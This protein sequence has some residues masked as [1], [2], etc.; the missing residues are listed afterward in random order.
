ML[1]HLWKCD[2]LRGCLREGLCHS[3]VEPRV[4][5]PRAI[6]VT[7]SCGTNREIAGDTFEKKKVILGRRRKGRTFIAL[8]IFDGFVSRPLCS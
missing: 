7:G 2:L 1:S 5:K 6:T 3:N 4:V 8:T